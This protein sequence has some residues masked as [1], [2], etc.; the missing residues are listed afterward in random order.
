MHS[1]LLGQHRHAGNTRSLPFYTH[2]GNQGCP[3]ASAARGAPSVQMHAVCTESAAMPSTRR[4]G[5]ARTRTQANSPTEPR[6]TAWPRARPAA[7]LHAGTASG[8]ALSKA[9]TMP[10]S[11]GAAG[12][13]SGSRAGRT[14]A[15]VSLL[16]RRSGGLL[17]TRE[18][19]GL[20]PRP[21][22][23]PA[24]RPPGLRAPAGHTHG[25]QTPRGRAFLAATASSSARGASAQ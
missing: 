23:P 9:S 14:P 4:R 2:S 18:R 6:L 10:G 15:P 22:R 3:V 5:Y 25:C 21:S 19:P 1:T 20:S 13:A 12:G 24:R 17:C 11:A 7:A 8:R 16:P